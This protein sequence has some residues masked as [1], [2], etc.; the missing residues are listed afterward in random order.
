M[1]L[2]TFCTPGALGKFFTG[3]D[4]SSPDAIAQ[5]GLGALSLGLRK[6]GFQTSSVPRE[7]KPTWL[8]TIEFFPHADRQKESN[9]PG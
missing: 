4:K 8:S 1:V 7:T 2:I 3:F 5:S 9:Q 6:G